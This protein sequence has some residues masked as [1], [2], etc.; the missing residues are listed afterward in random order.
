VINGEKW[1]VT[2]ASHAGYF[3]LQTKLE[4]GENE[5]AHCLFFI[6]MDSE[7]VEL[8]RTPPF[9]HRYASHHLAYRFNDVRV[10][11]TNRIGD[12]GGGMEYTYA[13]FRRERLMI[14]ARCCGAASRLIDEATTFARERIINGKPI[15]EYQTLCLRDGE[16][17]R[18]PRGA[19]LR[20]ARLYAQ[21]RRR[22]LLPRTSE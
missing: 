17:D 6:E 5:G 18:R 8:V 16:P 9:F 20:R 15:T 22:A 11:S 4:G 7:G 3:I 21:E 13:W 2:S 14:A 1:Y 12:E 10:P 19:D